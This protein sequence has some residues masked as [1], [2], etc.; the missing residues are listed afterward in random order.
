[1]IFGFL[2]IRLPQASVPP[3][4][5]FRGALLAAIGF[6]ILKI[7]GAYYLAIVGR[8]PAASAFGSILGVLIFFN[9][10]FRFLLFCMAWIA[11]AMESGEAP[12]PAVPEPPAPPPPTERVEPTPAPAGPSPTVVAGTLVGAGAAVGVGSVTAASLWRRA[13]RRSKAARAA[14]V[15]DSSAAPEKKTSDAE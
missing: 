12:K 5:A 10:V 3:G 1:V 11:T 8:S 13:R 2:L 7:I 14:L 4:L 15:R 6:E 9:L